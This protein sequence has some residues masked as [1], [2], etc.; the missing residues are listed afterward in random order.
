MYELP[1]ELDKRHKYFTKYNWTMRGIK[2]DDDEFDHIYNIYIHETNCDLCNKEFTKSHDR[3]LDHDHETGEVRNIV[4]NSCNRTKKDYKPFNN[5]S[6]EQHISITETGFAIRIV[7]NWKYILRKTRKTLE[8]AIIC[9]DE[10]IAN[11]PEI[12]K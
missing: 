2:I 4:C 7:R 1:F 11:N 9:R 3:H 10:F 12:F 5:N 8:E 6:G